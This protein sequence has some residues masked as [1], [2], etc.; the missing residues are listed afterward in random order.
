MS[1]FRQRH[2]DGDIVRLR[3]E[4][5]QGYALDLHSLRAAWGK[6]RVVGEYAHAKGLGALGDFAADA[7]KADDTEGLF[8]KL[9]AGEILPIP[10]P[11]FH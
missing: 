6:V 1:I 7:T 4:L 2:V 8:E 3:E 11:S 5:V 10:L 9:D